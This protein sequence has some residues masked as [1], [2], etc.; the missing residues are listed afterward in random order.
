MQ[1]EGIHSA[2]GQ[3]QAQARQGSGGQDFASKLAANGLPASRSGEA[4][5]G[6]QLLSD[7]LS[8]AMAAYTSVGGDAVGTK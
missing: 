7:D 5:S 1:T 2:W 4:R 8:R 6:G 3:Q